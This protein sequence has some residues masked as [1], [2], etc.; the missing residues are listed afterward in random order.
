MV[1]VW[2]TRQVMVQS[3]TITVGEASD[4]LNSVDRLLLVGQSAINKELSKA[5]IYDILSEAIHGDPGELIPPSLYRKLVKE[6]P[7][8]KS[9]EPGAQAQ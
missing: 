4:I 7:A 1:T 3:P 5:E 6:F 8:S 2:E 9:T